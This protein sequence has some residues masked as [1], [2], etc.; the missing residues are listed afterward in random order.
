MR[1]LLLIILLFTL[2][3]TGISYAEEKV[4]IRVEYL[5][6]SLEALKEHEAIT[7]PMDF[8]EWKLG[9]GFGKICNVDVNNHW[10]PVATT[11]E[12][13]ILERQGK[14][15]KIS[16]ENLHIVGFSNDTWWTRENNLIK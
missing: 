9:K 15:L 14:Y 16:G 7:N 8:Q 12:V 13:I 3:L 1:R 10:V 11:Y 2:C 6:T 4:L 5:Y